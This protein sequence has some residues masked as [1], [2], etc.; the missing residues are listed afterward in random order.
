MKNFELKKGVSSV[1]TRAWV[2]NVSET[3]AKLKDLGANFQTEIKINDEIYADLSEASADE[4]SFDSK[5][6]AAR[7]R[8]L[9]FEDKSICIATVRKGLKNISQEL[10]LHDVTTV[11]FYEETSK[12]NKSHL[13]KNLAEKGFPD[14]FKEI[15]KVRKIYSLNDSLIFID[16]VEGFSTV[17]EIRTEPENLQEAERLKMKQLTFLEELGIPSEDIIEKSHTHLILDKHIRSNSDIRLPY[18][19]KELE[20]LK[21]K[22]DA[23]L[24]KSNEHYREGGDGWHDN[25]SWDILMK[26]IEVLDVRIAKLKEEIY[27]ARNS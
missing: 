4:H 20:R 27:E 5:K 25:A 1:E 8:T 18:L 7:I 22:R 19:N 14:L 10:N 13:I 24:L 15:T 12:D 26:K 11:T 17:L 16:D 6:A 9:I 21:E 23:F 2:D 3:E